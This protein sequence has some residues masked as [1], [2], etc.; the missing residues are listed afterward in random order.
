MISTSQWLLLG[1]LSILWGG[2]FL[3]VGIAVAELPAFTIVLWRVGLAALLLLPVAVALRQRFPDMAQGWWPFLVMALLNNVIPFSAIALGQKGIA[4]GLA[5]VLN[6][7]T[8]LFAVTLTHVL[9]AD[10]MGSSRFAG[11]VIG[12][13]GVIVLIGPTLWEG[14]RTSTIG[15]VLVLIGTCSYGF[16]GV[17]GRRLRST[18]ALVSAAC[19]LVC[20][21]LLTALVAGLVDRPWTLPWPSQRT[22]L[23][24]LGLAALSTALAYALFFHILAV[25][26]PTNVM[27]VTLLIP[28]SGVALGALVLGETVHWH[29]VLGAIVIASGL[30]VVDGRLRSW[31]AAKR[32]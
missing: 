30:I 26:G 28:I 18:P 5:S 20:S 1:L 16:A 3:F 6:A 14:D 13:I 7:T 27:L 4:S 17:W 21:T 15:M 31:L 25:S 32:L 12:I 9:T 19:Q 10:K 8:P 23:A 11:V 29:H 22:T 2:S 24:M